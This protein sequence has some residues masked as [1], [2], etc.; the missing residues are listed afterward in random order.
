VAIYGAQHLIERKIHMDHHP[1]IQAALDVLARTF[2]RATARASSAL[3]I[4]LRQTY[5][6]AKR[7]AG[8][9]QA[10]WSFSTLTG[11]GFPLE[12]TFTSA[13]AHLRYAVDPA[14]P[15]LPPAQ[16]LANA[17]ELVAQLCQPLNLKLLE[18][19][20]AWQLA[21]PVGEL[22]YGAWIGG[23]HHVVSQS[24]RFKLYV[25][26]PASSAPGQG[27]LIAAHLN[28]QPRLPERELQLRML[29]LEPTTGRVEFYYRVHSLQSATL[30]HLLYP[31]GLR[32]RADELLDFVERAYGH[33]LRVVGARIP[34]GSVG[35]SYSVSPDDGR[36]AF[37]LFLFTRLLWGGDA[38]IRPRFR[39]RLETAGLDSAPYWQVTAA[40]DTRDVYQTYHGLI[41]FV[42]AS[43]APIQIS[44]GVRPPPM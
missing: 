36:V 34:G 24:D 43:D 7:S 27:S 44:L 11:D 40:L 30:S 28:P 10:A 33:S 39:E 22:R 5:I 14:R 4:L 42:V 9:H 2:P 18:E 8:D 29:G 15:G 23:R 12:W 17:A 32:S 38:R 16:R 1:D 35:F 31:A 20:M 13:D 19:L 21:A 25:E 26:V 6:G 41:G 37:T 3:S